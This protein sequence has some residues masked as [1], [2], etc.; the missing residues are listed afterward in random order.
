VRSAA[1]GSV[2]YA[3]RPSVGISSLKGIEISHLYSSRGVKWKWKV[4]SRHLGQSAERRARATRRVQVNEHRT[5]NTNTNTKEMAGAPCSCSAFVFSTLQYKSIH[6]LL[7]SYSVLP[8]ALAAARAPASR[9]T[10]R[11]HRPRT[12]A[13]HAHGAPATTAPASRLRAPPAS[14]RR[15]SAPWSHPHPHPHTPHTH[16]NMSYTSRAPPRGHRT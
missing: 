2:R 10:G 12:P 15:P 1:G 3:L 13:A 16:T 9:T 11:A 8:A 6:T 14:L 5:Q 4:G 7:Y